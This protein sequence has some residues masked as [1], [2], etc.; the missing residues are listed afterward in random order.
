MSSGA[1]LLRSRHRH[2][3]LGDWSGTGS[4]LI[5]LEFSHPN[6]SQVDREDEIIFLII[7]ALPLRLKEYFC[8]A[9]FGTSWSKTYFQTLNIYWWKKV[10]V[11]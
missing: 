2:V 4:N 3:T 8:T 11:L 1:C 7:Y 5:G 6:F 9:S 10:H